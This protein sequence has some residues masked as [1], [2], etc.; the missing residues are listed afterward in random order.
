MQTKSPHTSNPLILLLVIVVGVLLG[1]LYY[2]QALA[3]STVEIPLPD[4]ARD[5]SFLKFKDLKFDF[6]LFKDENLSTLKIYGEFPL[7]PGNTGKQDL[8]APF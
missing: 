8:F 7:A 2:S 4:A 1:Y 5:V 6:S 3:G